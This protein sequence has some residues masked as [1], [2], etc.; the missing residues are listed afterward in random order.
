MEIM[1]VHCNPTLVISFGVCMIS[2]MMMKVLPPAPIS[3]GPWKTRDTSLNE[4]LLLNSVSLI[5]SFSLDPKLLL[6][7]KNQ[8]PQ[9]KT[10]TILHTWRDNIELLVVIA[11][12]HESSSHG[13]ALRNSER[14]TYPLESPTIQQHP[15]QG[16]V[17]KFGKIASSMEKDYCPG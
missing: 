1:Y 5:H 2:V 16:F 14:S 15:F 11:V 7:H 3:T 10:N 12:G 17:C 6:P 4:N 9:K 8:Q 13:G